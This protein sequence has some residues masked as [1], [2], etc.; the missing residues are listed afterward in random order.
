[1]LYRLFLFIVILFIFVFIL[2][3]RQKLTSIVLPFA[4]GIFI[5]YI[6]NP[7]VEFLTSK[8]VK[9]A[10]A[11]AIIYFILIGSIIIALVYIVPVLIMELNNLIDVVPFYTREVQK[12]ISNIKIEYLSSLPLSLQ[13]IVD[14]NIDRLEKL[15]LD[16][17]EKVADTI[18]NAFSSMFSIILGPIL[19]FYI[20][21]DLDRIRESIIQYLPVNYRN[22]IILWF[23]KIG[24]TLGQYIRS[25]LIVS[26]IIGFLTTFVMVVIKIDF[27]FIIGALSGITNIIPYFGPLIGVM[28]AIIIAILRYPN[29]IPLIIISVFIIHQLESGIIS[30][31]IV[32]EHVGLH[33]LTVI[34]S[35]LIGGTFF[36]L[37]G[38]VLA[39]P[40]AALLKLTLQNMKENNNYSRL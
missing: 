26:L 14:S 29:K 15:L 7:V 23:E 19:G 22:S 31:H 13:E 2:N 16:C 6:L 8:G 37:L 35:L 25:Q 18:I 21:K 9:R 1:M 24:K 27:A 39:V 3:Q 17:L 38:L 11:V 5:A 40:I 4:I 30:P 33:P 32:G 34:L 10:A 20:L 36:G 28:P 12:I